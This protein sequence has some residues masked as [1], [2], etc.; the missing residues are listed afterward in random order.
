MRLLG[1]V[2]VAVGAGSKTYLGAKNEYTRAIATCVLIGGDMP[3]LASG[4]T[5]EHN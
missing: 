2:E 1:R 4:F 5:N 3:T